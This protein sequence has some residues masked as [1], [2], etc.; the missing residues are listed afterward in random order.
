MNKARRRRKPRRPRTG[1]FPS[2]QRFTLLDMSVRSLRAALS[3]VAVLALAFV[4]LTPA[5]S[6]GCVTSGDAARATE[7]DERHHSAHH[8]GSDHTPADGGSD[9][10]GCRCVTHCCPTL[11]PPATAHSQRAIVAAATGHEPQP[12]PR[13]VPRRLIAPYVL[14]FPLGPP[15]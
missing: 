15:A 3:G 5:E 10:S 1:Y 6:H 4:L 2:P 13:T 9:D 14:P 8:H 12:L 7:T 11:V